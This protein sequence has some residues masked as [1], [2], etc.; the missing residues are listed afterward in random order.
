MARNG[1]RSIAYT[2]ISK[3]LLYSFQTKVSPPRKRKLLFFFKKKKVSK[4][5]SL[6]AVQLKV[7]TVFIL[8]Y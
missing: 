3:H 1:S 8:I 7:F 6:T 5:H 4:I 2:T